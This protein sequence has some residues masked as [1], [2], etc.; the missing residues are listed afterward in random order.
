[1][2]SNLQNDIYSKDS[3]YQ[4]ERGNEFVNAI[5]VGSNF[6]CDF[7]TTN[8]TS[9]QMQV[10]IYILSKISN[11]KL[12][13]SSNSVSFYYYGP[14]KINISP[15]AD[16][17]TNSNLKNYNLSLST[18][19]PFD[20]GL[21]CEFSSIGDGIKYSTAKIYGNSIYCNIS[22]SNFSSST[23]IVQIKLFVNTSRL[24][25]DLHELSLKDEKFVLFKLPISFTTTESL[26]SF[27]MMKVNNYLNM[28]IPNVESNQGSLTYKVRYSSQYPNNDNGSSSNCIFNVNSQ[29][30]CINIPLN[31]QS[32]PAVYTLKISVFH[33]EN[34]NSFDFDV[35]PFTYYSLIPEMKSISPRFA[36]IMDTYSQKKEFQ[37]ELIGAINR[38]Q[39]TYYCKRSLNGDVLYVPAIIVQ[40]KNAFS[41]M[42]NNPV[43]ADNVTL[44]IYFESIEL[45]SKILFSDV[46]TI[47]FYK[48]LTI[49]KKVGFSNG[50]NIDVAI[51]S[52]YPTNYGNVY[53]YNLISNLLN[54]RDCAESLSIVRCFVN[55]S[56]F[57]QYP[58]TT[59]LDLMINGL[60]AFSL[61]PYLQINS[62]NSLN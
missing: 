13:F 28:T 21:V 7:E 36:S 54:I 43:N 45:K 14:T 61:I 53:S 47:N 12:K 19:Y 18:L 38:N 26:I 35:L 40:N 6:S 58:V 24:T 32:N 5:L 23:E 1:L 60:Y 62:K 4:C 46:R 9:R 34:N 27:D 59:Q 57:N 3:Y 37:I 2:I 42:L 55:E 8:S 10:S 25:T 22:K 39:F 17:F 15:F 29:P 56:S 51:P 48:S 33:P 31:P 16:T 20:I 44:S 41:F 30:Y 50:F 11:F 52:I 49:N